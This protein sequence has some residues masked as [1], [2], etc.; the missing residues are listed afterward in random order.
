M[1]NLT[2]ETKTHLNELVNFAV[3]KYG[4]EAMNKDINELFIEYTNHLADLVEKV[5]KVGLNDAHE[6]M[7]NKV[8]N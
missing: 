1:T 3:N 8:N 6:R 4:D 5:Q 7:W 2:A